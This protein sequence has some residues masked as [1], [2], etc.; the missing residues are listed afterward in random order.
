MVHHRNKSLE[1]QKNIINDLN[2]LFIEVIDLY[3]SVISFDQ[4]DSSLVIKT[5]D[6][7]P[8]EYEECLEQIEF[9]SKRLTDYIIFRCDSFNRNDPYG[10]YH[11]DTDDYNTILKCTLIQ[12]TKLL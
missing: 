6:L 12:K 9:C 11:F 3:D 1:I 7:D 8:N 2:L 10:Y 4:I 5:Y